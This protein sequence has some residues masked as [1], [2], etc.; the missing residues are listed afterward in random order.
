MRRDKNTCI[1]ARK[2]IHVRGISL[3]ITNRF[4][5]LVS[6]IYPRNHANKRKPIYTAPQSTYYMHTLGIS[7]MN[8]A[9]AP[10]CSE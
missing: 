8:R 4:R 7:E 9:V 1:R 5:S 6:A 2:S 10:R 3:Y